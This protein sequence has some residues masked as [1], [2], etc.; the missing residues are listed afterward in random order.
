MSAAVT[1][2]D[3]VRDVDN[4]RAGGHRSLAS[5]T[6]TRSHSNL[7]KHPIIIPNPN[8]S[9]SVYTLGTAK[10]S[11]GCQSPFNYSISIMRY[12]PSSTP[13]SQVPCRIGS[14]D[15]VRMGEDLVIKLKCSC[16]SFFW[17][18]GYASFALPRYCD[19]SLRARDTI[20]RAA[21]QHLVSSP[22]TQ[23]DQRDVPQSTTTQWGFANCPKIL[24][25]R[26]DTEAEI[27][28]RQNFSVLILTADGGTGE[29]GE[30]GNTSRTVANFREEDLPLTRTVLLLPIASL[31]GVVLV[32]DVALG[33]TG[34]GFVRP[35][36][37]RDRQAINVLPPFAIPLQRNRDTVTRRE[38]QHGVGKRVDGLTY[39][40]CECRMEDSKMDVAA[41]ATTPLLRSR[42]AGFRG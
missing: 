7:H 40:Q 41:S 14:G 6:L 26:K 37:G 27:R 42:D 12:E 16:D 33:L 5:C 9:T 39:V 21:E 35:Y 10:P 28:V 30:F 8:N 2:V 13:R 1:A 3:D 36:D 23:G 38:A 34:S 4:D 11:K 15:Y 17:G 18:E 22:E 31:Q 24:P 19:V 29:G 25:P 20:Q 32:D